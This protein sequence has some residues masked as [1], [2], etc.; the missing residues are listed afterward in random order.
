VL[1]TLNVPGLWL[2]G[3]EDRSIPTPATV[4]ILDQLIASGKPYSRVVFPDLATIF[5]APYWPEIDKWLSKILRSGIL[6]GHEN[7]L[8][9]ILAVALA[10]SVRAQQA[11]APR[12]ATPPV[13]V[14]QKDGFFTTSDG[15]KIHYL[16]ARRR[17]R[18]VGRARAR[19]LRQ[20]AAHVVQHR[21]RAGD[22]E[23]SS[24]RRDRQPQSRAERQA[25]PGGSAARRTSSS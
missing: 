24:R 15:I 16:H 1:E 22:R 6:C 2:L 7:R 10:T 12:P 23:A 5:H 9:L 20:R 8:S 21:H 25:G 18:I 14:G 13:M 11:A 17:Q 3:G 19:L 4:E